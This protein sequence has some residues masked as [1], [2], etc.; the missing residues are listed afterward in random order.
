MECYLLAQERSWYDFILDGMTAGGVMKRLDLAI[1]D[2]AGILDIP[3]L[4]EKYKAGECISY[5]RMPVS[6]THLF[7][8]TS[9]ASCASRN[10]RFNRAISFASSEA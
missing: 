5:F 2:K 6:Y 9:S 10:S 7:F 3:K 8:N 1:N 4:K